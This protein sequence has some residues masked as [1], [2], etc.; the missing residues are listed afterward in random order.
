MDLLKKFICN[1]TK[2]TTPKIF[3]PFIIALTDAVIGQSLVEISKSMPNDQGKLFIKTYQST[4][5][6][7]KIQDFNDFVKD[8]NK[9]LIKAVTPEQLMSFTANFI[10]FLDKEFSLYSNS[11]KFGATC[12][13]VFTIVSPYIITLIAKGTLELTFKTELS[14]IDD[15]EVKVKQNEDAINTLVNK[16]ADQYTATT[17]QELAQQYIKEFS[18]F[19]TSELSTT[20]TTIQASLLGDFVSLVNY[21]IDSNINL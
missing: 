8:I 9:N 5:E 21:E 17:S 3:A 10:A 11:H 13:W 16:F 12:Q 1:Q 19:T 15:A 20:S 2:D 18:N 4:L 14:K 7:D 6:S